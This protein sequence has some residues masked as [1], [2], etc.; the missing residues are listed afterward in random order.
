MTYGCSIFSTLYGDISL[1]LA[2]IKAIY[3]DIMDKY[4]Y[5]ISMVPRSM[6]DMKHAQGQRILLYIS[7]HMTYGVF[8]I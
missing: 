1:E 5:Q 8:Y 4:A 2:T 7:C 3:I 6:K